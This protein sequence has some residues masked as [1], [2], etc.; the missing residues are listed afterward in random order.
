MPDLRSR[1]TSARELM[2]D[3]DAD[4]IALEREQ[5]A[6][7]AEWTSTRTYTQRV[8]NII[9]G[10][11]GGGVNGSFFLN[12]N[13]NVDDDLARDTLTGSAGRDW[14]Q[15]NLD[16]FSLFRDQITDLNGGELASD[17]D[18]LGLI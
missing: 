15:A 1:D 10:S 6:I 9:D 4:R 13:S 7:L 16:I 17:I 14:V 5:D 18:F 2:D 11:G 3:P 12:P 8:N